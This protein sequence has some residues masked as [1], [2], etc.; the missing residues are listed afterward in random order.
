MVKSN[1]LQPKRF[2]VWLINLD[3]K[4]GSEIKKTRPGLVISPNEINSNLNTMIIA[5]MSTKSKNYPTHIPLTFQKKSG[6]IIL[7]QLRTIDKLRLVKKLG[8]ISQSTA[9]KT[10][11]KIQELFAF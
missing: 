1:P 10:C 9:Q 6:F 4:V 2:E 5:P 3:P 11:Q 7:E 8:E